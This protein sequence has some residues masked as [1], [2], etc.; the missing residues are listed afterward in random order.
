MRLRLALFLLLVPT[1]CFPQRTGHQLSGYVREE[2]TNV[3]VDS[4]ALEI[5]SSGQR[6]APAVVSGM[7]GEFGFSG[8]RDGDY[9]IVAT[10]KGYDTL[11][12]QVSILSGS[13][14]PVVVPLHKQVG[15]KP[16]ASADAVS[17]RELSIP[18]KARDSFAKGRKLMYEK[19]DPKKAIEQFRLAVDQFPTYYE[20][21]TQIGVAHYRLNKFADAEKA[22]KKAIEMSAGKYP[23]ALY[24]L[25]TMFNDQE[26]FAEAE[27][28][29]RQ[30]AA[31][32]DST[33][34]GPYELARALVGLKRAAE[35]EASAAQARDMKPDN[36]QVYLVL[37]NA[38]IQQK[39]FSAV[40][41]DFDS[42]LKLAPN[43]PGSDQIRLRRDRMQEAL[44]R[45]ASQQAPAPN[46]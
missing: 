41:Q 8:L 22:L 31:A 9:N 19:S 44:R 18:E 28:L 7:D 11:T 30:A 43:A 38:H 25:A 45:A 23:D 39:K 21:Y 2:T 20:A 12:V 27:P 46:Q 34:H 10:K 1:L 15:P 6:V 3:P 36:A 42:Y 14:P 5:F 37:A 35:A 26:R 29:A 33:W 24:L 17:A 16:S 40:V 32:G 4:V 13:V